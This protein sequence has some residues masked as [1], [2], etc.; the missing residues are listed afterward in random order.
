[1]YKPA[2]PLLLF[3]SDGS[4]QK[5]SFQSNSRS[6]QGTTISISLSQAAAEELKT[7]SPPPPPPRR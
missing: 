6:L 3:H 2:R 7:F 5:P 4:H 1:M